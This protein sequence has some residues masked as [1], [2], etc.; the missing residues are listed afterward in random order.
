MRKRLPRLVLLA[1]VAVLLTSCGGTSSGDVTMT[2]PF[3]F[4]ENPW[5]G[6][7]TLSGSAV[8]DG[9]VCSAGEA[10]EQS[11]AE[12]ARDSESAT[13]RLDLEVTCADGSGEFVIRQDVVIPMEDGEFPE[14][15]E[16]I[17]DTWTVLSGIGD[18]TELQGSGEG[19]NTSDDPDNPISVFTGE[20]SNG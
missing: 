7:V 8:D 17:S 6:P 16:T 20:L 10:V 14:D 4:I 5:Q 3:N 12:T 2:W 11:F 1:G 9:V 19:T 15:F 13:F 18:Y